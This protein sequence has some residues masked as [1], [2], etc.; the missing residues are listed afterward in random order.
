MVF[1]RGC[2]APQRESRTCAWERWVVLHHK[3]NHFFT[4]SLSSLQTEWFALLVMARIY[5]SL[6]M[7]SV[8][9]NRIP[10]I[11]PPPIAPNSK[12]G[13]DRFAQ[14]TLPS[15]EVV[16]KLVGKNYD[17]GTTKRYYDRAGGRLL[18]FSA[19]VVPPPGVLQIPLY[20]LPAPDMRFVVVER[21]TQAVRDVPNLTRWMYLN[22]HVQ[23]SDIGSIMP[24]P[25]P[26]VLS[27]MDTL[28]NA[29][30]QQDDLLFGMADDGN[31][32]WSIPA[33]Y[34]ALYTPFVSY[35]SLSIHS[36]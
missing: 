9:P 26:L 16:M 6:D 31:A 34:E 12:L 20:G 2:A 25:N 10:W 15:G 3:T 4:S 18:A 19:P 14:V 8:A 21:F 33:N 1:E 11:R 22:A 27:T 35:L 24:P 17:L 32:R 23:S 5:S 13:F 36:G 29:I 7:V 30:Q 28:A